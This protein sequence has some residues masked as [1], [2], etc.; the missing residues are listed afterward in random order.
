MVVACGGYG[1]PQQI[2]IIIHS[3]DNCTQEKQELR[4]FIRSFS[5]SEQVYARIG[6]DRPVVVL[7]RAVDICK[8]LFVQQTNKTVLFCDLL[9]YLHSQLVVIGSDVGRRI[10]RCKLVLC[11]CD[12]VVLCFCKYAELPQFVVQ[13]GHICL[14]TRLDDTKIVVVKLLSLWRLCAEKRPARVYKI[15]ALVVKLLGDKE[16]FL[17]RS[18][19]GRNVLYSV[20]SKQFQDTHSLLVERLHRAQQ[21]SFLIKCLAAV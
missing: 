8:R 17:L 6:S 12:L 1:D 2:L 16:V 3:L 18:D 21:R 13:V 9:H 19:R 20:I 4:I 5:R 15:L 10:D 14:D 11:G 7:A